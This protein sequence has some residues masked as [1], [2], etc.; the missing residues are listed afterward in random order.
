MVLFSCKNIDTVRLP[1]NDTIS[2]ILTFASTNQELFSDSREISV[3]WRTWRR[4]KKSFDI[5]G[6]KWEVIFL[7][8]VQ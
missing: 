2:R 1:E 8:K 6:V 3:G 4:Y 5:F 7:L